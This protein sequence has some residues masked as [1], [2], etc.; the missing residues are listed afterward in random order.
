MACKFI[1]EINNI[2]INLQAISTSSYPT[3]AERPKYSV[4]DKSKI[5]ETF[6]IKIKSWDENLKTVV[7]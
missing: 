5:I 6:G 4:L 2:N 1:F 3:P 7:I